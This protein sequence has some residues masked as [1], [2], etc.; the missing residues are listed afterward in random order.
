MKTITLQLS[1]ETAERLDALAERLGVSP[2]EIAQ[3]S[4]RDQLDQ[5]DPEFED[6]AEEVLS[7]NSELYR[8]L[9]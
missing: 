4:I 5:I 8:R 6:A 2:E 1:N 7:K 9:A 3:A